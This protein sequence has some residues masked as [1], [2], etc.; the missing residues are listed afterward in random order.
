MKLTNIGYDYGGKVA[1]VTLKT[2]NEADTK[3]I[4]AIEFYLAGDK[5]KLEKLLG[6]DEMKEKI[7]K[8]IDT[9]EANSD[10]LQVEI[11]NLNVAYQQEI[12]NLKK[13]VPEQLWV[14]TFEDDP[15]KQKV[16]P[17]FNDA[18]IFMRCN[19]YTSHDKISKGVYRFRKRGKT[20][21]E[22]DYHIVHR[23]Q[24]IHYA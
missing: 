2:Q 5:S 13:K 18:E 10:K 7:Q 14:S 16:F 17:T 23:V 15:L 11:A 22:T 24:V 20:N 12:N 8:Y 9:I 6:I 3:L 21:P 19:G 4:Q 1:E